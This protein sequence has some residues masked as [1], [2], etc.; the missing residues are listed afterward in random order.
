MPK[1]GKGKAQRAKI[2]H[3]N[4]RKA[5]KVTGTA[6][7]KERVERVHQETSLKMGLLVD[8]LLWFQEHADPEK[9]EYTRVELCQLVEGYLHRFDEELEQIDII[10]GMKARKGRQ[11][12]AR[13]DI[14]KSTMKTERNL[15]NTCGLEAPDLADKKNL[16][17]FLE[18]DG[19]AKHASLIKMRKVVARKTGAQTTEG[20]IA[21]RTDMQHDG[22]T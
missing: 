13:E 19:T 10:Q 12:A 3:P 18:W 8:K 15:F 21:S 2:L 11:H 20:S 16:A 9:T 1:A 7:R 22:T 4:S 6:V 5:M 17:R 14:I